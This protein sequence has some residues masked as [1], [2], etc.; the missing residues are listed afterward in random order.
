MSVEDRGV[1]VPFDKCQRRILREKPVYHVKNEILYLV[2]GEVEYQLISE[3][4]LRP[5]LLADDPVGVIV[6]KRT[7]GIDHLRLYPYAKLNPRFFS[8][9]N[10]VGNTV[11]QLA[12]VHLPV[13]QACL[14]VVTWVRSEERRVGK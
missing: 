1:A 10:Q 2:I 12:S 3:I 13:A 7:L 9:T 6:V 11:G 5:I 4:D 14:V 8:L